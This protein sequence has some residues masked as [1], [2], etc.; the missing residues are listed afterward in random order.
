MDADPD[1]EDPPVVPYAIIP[2]LVSLA[3]ERVVFLVPAESF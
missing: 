2:F 1:A 3:K